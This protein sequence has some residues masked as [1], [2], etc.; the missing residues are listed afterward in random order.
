MNM[1]NQTLHVNLELFGNV[2]CANHLRHFSDHF[3]RNLVPLLGLHGLHVVRDLLYMP[4]SVVVGLDALIAKFTSSVP[5][6]RLELVH[7]PLGARLVFR[8]SRLDRV[9]HRIDVF[10]EHFHCFQIG[11]IFL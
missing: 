10:A 6:E 9:V 3:D 7:Q 2:V 1:P 5:L 11:R 4:S 8:E